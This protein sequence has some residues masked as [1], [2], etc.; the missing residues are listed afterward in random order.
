MKSKGKRDDIQT[1]LLA[2]LF[3]WQSELNCLNMRDND[4]NTLGPND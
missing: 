1:M 3:N 4:F 2:Y